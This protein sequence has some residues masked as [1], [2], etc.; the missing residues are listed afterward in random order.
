MLTERQA[1]RWMPWAWSAAWM[2]TGVGVS[3]SDLYSY[4]AQSLIPYFALSA[5]GWSAAGIVTASASRREPGMAVRLV[6]W[7]VAY[8]AAIPLGLVWLL[9]WN[10][11]YLG[12]IVAIGVAGA[13]GGV[14]GSLRSGAWRLVSGVLLGLAF[15]L[16]ATVSFSASYILLVLYAPIAQLLGNAGADL[17]AWGLPSALCGLAAG[18]AARRILGITAVDPTSVST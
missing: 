1:Y 3:I 11:A 6:G 18:F 12:P 13:I 16:F 15:L 5:V 8:L 10:V 17:L 7:A 2:L 14:A 9:S 4:P